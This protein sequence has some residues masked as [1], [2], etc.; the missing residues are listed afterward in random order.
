MKSA[1]K[2]GT[3]IARADLRVTDLGRHAY[4]FGKIPQV[5]HSGGRP[6]PTTGYGCDRS[7]PRKA[8]LSPG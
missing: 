4:L 7:W 1:A 5:K 6:A 3:K 2:C 8:R